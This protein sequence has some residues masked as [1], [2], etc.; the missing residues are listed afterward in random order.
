MDKEKL[1]WLLW[2]TVWRPGQTICLSYVLKNVFQEFV[3]WRNNKLLFFSF[4]IKVVLTEET[5]DI[6]DYYF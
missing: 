3:S 5:Y 4:N 6:I 1:I 2:D